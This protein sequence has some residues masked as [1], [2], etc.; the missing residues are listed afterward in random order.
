MRDR[1]LEVP[2]LQAMT[3]GTLAAVLTI[4]IGNFVAALRA[5]RQ[6]PQNRQS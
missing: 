3:L 1:S 5:F 2:R 4:V 6:R